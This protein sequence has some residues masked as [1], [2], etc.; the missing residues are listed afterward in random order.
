MD[1]LVI[2]QF[3]T[4]PLVTL[5]IGAGKFY[6]DKQRLETKALIDIQSK[7]TR[8]LIEEVKTSL[9]KEIADIQTAIT[10]NET[11]D[12]WREEWLKRHD[13]EIKEIKRKIYNGGSK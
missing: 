3:A 13:E 10:T 2:F 7:T 1:W 12:K 8:K 11:D 4:P 6:S 9:T 5:A